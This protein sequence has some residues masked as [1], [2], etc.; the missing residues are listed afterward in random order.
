MLSFPESGPELA[1]GG[2]G[3]GGVAKLHLVGGGPFLVGSLPCPKSSP[4]VQPRFSD[5]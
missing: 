3:G 2:G 4:D 5:W 1:V